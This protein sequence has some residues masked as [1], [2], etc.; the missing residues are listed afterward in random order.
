[1]STAAITAVYPRNTLNLGRF[2][3]HIED[4]ARYLFRALHR[5]T[6]KRERSADFEPVAHRHNVECAASANSPIAELRRHR[7]FHPGG[8]P[9]AQTEFEVNFNGREDQR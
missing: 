5:I 1:M 2:Q 6:V 4:V 3:P 9:N 7:D 8:E